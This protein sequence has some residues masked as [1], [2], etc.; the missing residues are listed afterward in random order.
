MGKYEL[1]VEGGKML[2]AECS[3]DNNRI[4][5]VKISGDFFLHPEESITTLE[6]SL[7]DIK[8]DRNEVNSIVENFIDAGNT[9]IGVG[10]SHI[11]EAIIKASSI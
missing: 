8:A 4:K 5:S 6:E 7:I 2:R 1:K 10:K 3:V 9:F 11:V